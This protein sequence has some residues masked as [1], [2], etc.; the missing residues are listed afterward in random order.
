[1]R[2]KRDSGAVLFACGRITPAC[3]GKTPQTRWRAV[4]SGDHP[5]VCG[6]NPAKPLFMRGCGGSPPRVRG[7]PRKAFVYAG[8]RRITPACAGKTKI[9]PLRAEE[10][11]DHPRVCGENDN[12]GLLIRDSWGSPPRVRGK[13]RYSMSKNFQERITPACAGKTRACGEY[14]RSS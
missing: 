14:V 12:S 7:K 4:D 1:M 3:A 8:L 10:I 2:G 9:R 5:R 13:R 6:E 11:E